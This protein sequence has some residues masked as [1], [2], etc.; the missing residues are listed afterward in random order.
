MAVTRDIT[1]ISL[2]PPRLAPALP[3]TRARTRRSAS[4]SSSVIASPR[5]ARYRVIASSHT[6]RMQQTTPLP[7]LPGYKRLLAFN[8][9]LSLPW[10]LP[11]AVV[12]SLL[13]NALEISQRLSDLATTA[14]PT[15]P[16]T[17]KALTPIYQSME[18][19]LAKLQDI[20]TMDDLHPQIS[21]PGRPGIDDKVPSPTVRSP[22][23]SFALS[24]S[25]SPFFPGNQLALRKRSST[26]P[27]P[28]PERPLKKRASQVCSLR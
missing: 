13:Q 23:Q 8:D 17:R 4:L 12:M 20:S 27:S 6:R 28:T 11:A 24:R 26:P 7:P 5:P 21:S 16:V 19:S 2:L 25:P 15:S 14:L 10:F 3:S 18:H 9:H 22:H 1:L